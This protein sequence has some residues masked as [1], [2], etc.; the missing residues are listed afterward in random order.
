MVFLAF[1]RRE[2]KYPSSE[3]KDQK[4][5][6]A[7]LRAAPSA[8]EKERT[9]GELFDAAEKQKITALWRRLRGDDNLCQKV[10]RAWFI[11]A[12]ALRQKVGLRP[13]MRLGTRTLF[14]GQWLDCYCCFPMCADAGLRAERPGLLHAK[15]PL[16]GRGLSVG[17]A[18]F[19]HS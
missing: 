2:S 3:T 12:P 5:S 17:P 6:V 11:A 14:G 13:T 10:L 8:A 9:N 1:C 16:S 15:K 4:E 18:V 7:A 19:V